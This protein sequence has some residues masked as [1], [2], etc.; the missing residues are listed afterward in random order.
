MNL[1][2]S[3]WFYWAVGVAVGLPLGLIVL[4]ECHHALVRRQSY[5]AR[6]VALLR[7]Y[8][9]P[10]GALLLLLV[11]AAQVPFRDVSVRVLATVFSFLVLVL[12]LSGLSATLF[13]GA[14]QGS[15][16]KRVPAI[17]LDVA[18]FVLIGVGLAVIFSYVWGVRIGGVFAA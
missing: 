4:T 8:L 11:E 9:L 16:R 18:R 17:F 6:P 3:S 14:P 7:N 1:F 12:L 2:D 15:W 13:Q 10:L 5:L